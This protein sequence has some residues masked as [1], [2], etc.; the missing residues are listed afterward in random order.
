MID[1]FWLSS[2]CDYCGAAPYEQC[3]TATGGPA[4]THGGRTAI[5]AAAY[6]AGFENGYDAASE[7]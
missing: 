5:Q 3:K 1:D 4:S 7:N 2:P 6:Q